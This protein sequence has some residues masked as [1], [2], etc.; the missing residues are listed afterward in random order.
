MHVM[1]GAAYFTGAVSYEGKMF[2]KSTN[3]T[4]REVLLREKAQYN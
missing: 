4:A 3:S 1:D 2:M